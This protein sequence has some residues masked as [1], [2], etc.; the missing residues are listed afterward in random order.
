MFVLD[1]LLSGFVV[2]EVDLAGH[3]GVPIELSVLWVGVSM[4]GLFDESQVHQWLGIGC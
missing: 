4:L 1:D 3:Y 2:P